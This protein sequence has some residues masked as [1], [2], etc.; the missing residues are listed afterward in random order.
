MFAGPEGV[1]F[2]ASDL[3]NY[4]GCRHATFLDLES[5]GQP[6]PAAEPDPT[7]DLLK[8]K[9]IEHEQRYLAFLKSQGKQVAVIDPKANIDQRV[10]QTLSAMSNGAEELRVA[11]NG[12]HLQPNRGPR[13]LPIT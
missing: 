2:S 11:R 7:G 6:E 9:G 10:A 1:I 13:R 3:I 5:P 12:F 8:R 4:L